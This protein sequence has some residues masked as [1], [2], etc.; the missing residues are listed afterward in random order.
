HRR[1]PR[2]T[3]GSY[4]GIR[5]SARYDVAAIGNAIVDVIA[6]AEDRFLVNNGLTKGAMILV[7]EDQA[8]ALYAK[9]A[10]GLETSGGSAGNTIAGVA[11]LGGRAAYVGKVADDQLGEVFAHD[12]RAI[13]ATYDVA[14]LT[15]GPATGR[16]LINV[17]ADGQRT[18]CT[19]LGASNQLTA[20]DVEP[21]VIE[22]AAIVYLEGYLFDPSEARRAFAKAAGL[23]RASG[24]TI[25]LTLSD[26]FVVERHRQAL[27]DFIETEV[28][29]LFA[30]E[31]VITSLFET[32]DFDAALAA[33]RS[34]VRIA[35]LTRSE[36]GSV[37]V[38]ADDECAVPAR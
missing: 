36:R 38:T 35:A 12:M 3:G 14:P 28:D 7:D 21:S 23:A 1:W 26:A 29:L 37:V 27:L 24:R 19:Y 30:N 31:A 32:A 22:G 9:M 16:S 25:A 33:I 15:N 4:N 18:M 17:T 6:P 10:P 34:R 13:G 5:M 11:S 20:A 2:A 8:Q